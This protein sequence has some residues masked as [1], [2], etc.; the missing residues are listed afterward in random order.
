MGRWSLCLK[1]QIQ[2]REILP[3]LVEPYVVAD[4]PLCADTLL[5]A[6]PSTLPDSHL[7]MDWKAGGA[8]IK[9][10]VQLRWACLNMIKLRYVIRMKFLDL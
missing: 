2:L 8:F 4:L 3:L 9:V 6:T 7:E 1:S 10:Y 5:L